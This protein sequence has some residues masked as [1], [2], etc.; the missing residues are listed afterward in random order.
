[1]TSSEYATCKYARGVAISAR[2]FGSNGPGRVLVTPPGRDRPGK[3]ADMR[4]VPLHG[5]KAGGRVALVDDADYDLVMAYRWNIRETLRPGRRTYGPYAEA[6][7]R[8]DGRATKVQMHGLITGWLMVDHKDHDGLNN[9]RSNLR[10]A[11]T[12]QNN[13]NQRPRI[14][15]SSQYKGVTWHKKIRKWQATIKIGG[16]CRYLGVFAVEQEAA[17][18]YNAAA[19]EAYGEYAHLNDVAA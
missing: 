3:Q 10:P 14:G 12:A 18:A 1:M 7:A 19:L 15:H 16:K 9:Q 13:H 4:T 11:T 8:R 6:Y 5:K 2:L 17:R